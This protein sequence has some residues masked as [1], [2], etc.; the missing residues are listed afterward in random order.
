MA[1]AP[2]DFLGPGRRRA[3]E[4]DDRS[5]PFS[6][7]PR[8]ERKRRGSTPAARV[9]VGCRMTASAIDW[10]DRKANPQGGQEPVLVRH[11]QA[12]TGRSRSKFRRR[13]VRAIRTLR[14]PAFLAS[15]H[16][17]T[18]R[19]DTACGESRTPRPVDLDE[20]SGCTYRRCKRSRRGA[21]DGGSCLVGRLDR[22]PRPDGR[23]RFPLARVIAR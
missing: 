2:R 21:R 9:I 4:P 5:E 12:I 11:R 7:C 20:M 18:L 14:P 13:A 17:V 19:G 6:P 23:P 1:A 8:D 3:V 16:T 15:P 10:L 22:R